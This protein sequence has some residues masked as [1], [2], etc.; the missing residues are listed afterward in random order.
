[1]ERESSPPSPVLE[2]K[3]AIISPKSPGRTTIEDS[4]QRGKSNAFENFIQSYSQN[5]VGVDALRSVV[6]KPPISEERELP[7][8]TEELVERAKIVL[9]LRQ[10]AC[11]KW[12]TRE[13]IEKEREAKRSINLSLKFQSP[14]LPPPPPVKAVAR[15]PRIL[16]NNLSMKKRRQSYLRSKEES[17][18]ESNA[19]L[20]T[21]ADGDEDNDDDEDDKLSIITTATTDISQVTADDSVESLIDLWFQ[22]IPDPEMNVG[23]SEVKTVASA[24]KNRKLGDLINSVL[25]RPLSKYANKEIRVATT[26][27][28]FDIIGQHLPPISA[29]ELLP[30]VLSVTNGRSF[31]QSQELKQDLFCAEVCY[32]LYLSKDL[33]C[34]EIIRIKDNPSFQS[35]PSRQVIKDLFGKF[36]HEFRF[37]DFLESSRQVCLHLLPSFP[38]P[39][40]CMCIYVTSTCLLRSCT[41]IKSVS[42]N[43]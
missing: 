36:V 30:I 26:D 18:E 38:F 14:E 29:G 22:T 7:P 16:P 37:R 28:E 33:D 25:I 19:S 39:C 23:S 27:G 32:E 3:D 6:V 42:I 10:A 13:S 41:I 21:I 20:L 40:V 35:L 9:R 5:K 24:W 8:D 17:E 43:L 11:K 34:W 15:S 2:T 1:L 4:D 12:W 31:P